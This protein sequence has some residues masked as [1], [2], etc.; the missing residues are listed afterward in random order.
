M[1]TPRRERRRA[2]APSLVLGTALGL[3]LGVPLGGAAV[4]LWKPTPLPIIVEQMPQPM[5]AAPLPTSDEPAEDK[6]AM[7]AKN[8]PGET[9]TMPSTV[10]ISHPVSLMD[11]R[12]SPRDD[13]TPLGG[14]ASRS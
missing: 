3:L 4:W 10:S 14:R 9:W 12:R 8:V 2:S 13:D 1:A 6:T 11:Q 7:M 5:R